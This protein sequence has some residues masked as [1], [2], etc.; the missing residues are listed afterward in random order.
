M[1]ATHSPGPLVSTWAGSVKRKA[2]A[3]SSCTIR[4]PKPTQPTIA[5]NAY[6]S[7]RSIAVGRSP[8]A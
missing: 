4:Q 3:A 6:A 2:P 5:R 1:A 7:Q 8:T